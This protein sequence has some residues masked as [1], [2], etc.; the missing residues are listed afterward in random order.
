[1]NARPV[2]QAT[3]MH[4]V[5]AVSACAL[6]VGGD[7]TTTPNPPQDTTTVTMLQLRKVAENRSL[8]VAVGTAAGSLFNATDAV[9][10]QY[11]TVLS[12]EFNV[13]TP[14]NE[15]KFSSIRPNTFPGQGEALL[16]DASFQPKLAY[17][18]V[19]DVLSGR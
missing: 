5:R 17:R 3:V 2:S 14:D 6:L 4:G 10:T 11:M 9:G 13:L 18:A 1:V 12:R 7:S 19:N 15:M 8:R 16:F